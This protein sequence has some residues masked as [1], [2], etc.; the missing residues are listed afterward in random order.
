MEVV[1]I[2]PESLQVAHLLAAMTTKLRDTIALKGIPKTREEL[3]LEAQRVEELL[4]P[5]DRASNRDT[6]QTYQ[7]NQYQPPETK[8]PN[9]ETATNQ[10]NECLRCGKTDHT[11]SRCPDI[12]C[13]QCKGTGHISTFCPQRRN[14]D[15][16]HPRT[17][18]AQ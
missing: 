2:L 14:Q 15:T 16:H 17:S 18:R 12:Q 9:G 1:D 11:T 5:R 8:Q 10:N 7:R 6:T 13:Y 4:G 3:I